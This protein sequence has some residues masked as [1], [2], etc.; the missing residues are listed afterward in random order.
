MPFR[1]HV[2]SPDPVSRIGT[3]IG[4]RDS[5]I[6][7]GFRIQSLEDMP[8]FHVHLCPNVCGRSAIATRYNSLQRPDHSLYM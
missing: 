1:Y 8:Q 6:S 4:L 2:T 7:L 5:R 3:L